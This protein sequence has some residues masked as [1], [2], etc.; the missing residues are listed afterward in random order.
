MIQYPK[1]VCSLIIDLD[2]LILATSRKNDHSIFGLPGGKVDS[3]DKTLESAAKRELEEETGVIA[4]GGI[5]IFTSICYGHDNKGYMTTTFIWN[6]CLND[7]KQ[8]EGEGIV[9]WVSP[10]IMCKKHSGVFANFGFYNYRLF[11]Y[12]DIYSSPEERFS[13]K[14]KSPF[15]KKDNIIVKV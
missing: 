3:D 7:P 14:G 2:G 5:P 1:A 4:E 11:Q 6:K 8:I 12:L 13:I 15:A 10:H 9:A